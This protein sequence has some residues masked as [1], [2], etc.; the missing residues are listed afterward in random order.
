MGTYITV[1]GKFA[2]E[3]ARLLTFL[4]VKLVINGQNDK[5]MQVFVFKQI[6]SSGWEA[7]NEILTFL[8]LWGVG[9]IY[10]NGIGC[11]QSA[12]LV[13]QIVAM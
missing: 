3:K 1:G 4:L 8:N 13:A 7:L 12:W 10:L 2:P 11:T 9:T 6:I 5:G